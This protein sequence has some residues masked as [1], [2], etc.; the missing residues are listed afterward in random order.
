[1]AADLAMLLASRKLGGINIPLKYLADYNIESDPTNS[2]IPT[3]YAIANTKHRQGLNK[4]IHRN[5]KQTST[6][7]T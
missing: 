5:P 7:I 2:T 4:N 1:M 6:M 3:S